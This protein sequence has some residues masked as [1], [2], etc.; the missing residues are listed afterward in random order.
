MNDQLGVLDELDELGRHL[1]ELRLLA[2][3][4]ARDAVHL[5]G[6]GVDVAFGIEIAVENPAG[7]API[8]QLDATD[9]DDA[10]LLLD[11]E[12]RGFRIEDDLAHGNQPA[13]SRRSIAWF[14]SSSTN[15]LP[16][17]PECPL[18]HCQ[19]ISWAASAASRRSHRS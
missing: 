10:V 6:A 5:L 4:L 15:S 17:R 7:Q 18:T 11:F 19:S 13:A 14:A 16:S 3:L 12:A 1:G 2:Q 8:E 9:L